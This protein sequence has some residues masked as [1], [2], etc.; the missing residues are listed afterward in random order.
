M[1]GSE[2]NKRRPTDV[3]RPTFDV[4]KH[5]KNDVQNI[6][7][8][9]KSK[10]AKFRC[11][12]I[13]FFL[14]VVVSCFWTSNLGLLTSVGHRLFC[15]ERHICWARFSPNLVFFYFLQLNPWIV[16]RFPLKLLAYLSRLEGLLF[17]V[18][19]GIP[20]SSWLGNALRTPGTGVQSGGSP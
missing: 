3:K 11:T 16:F 1:W 8:V 18:S 14:N 5:E 12:Y 15:S 7:E 19:M 4:Q 17:S 20:K 13:E 9:R 10:F 2:Q 6:F